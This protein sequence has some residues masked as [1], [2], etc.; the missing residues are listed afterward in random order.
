LVTAI[1]SASIK[2]TKT[3]FIV[4]VLGH[5]EFLDVE[6]FPVVVTPRFIQITQARK[7]K[8]LKIRSKILLHAGIRKSTTY[9]SE[10]QTN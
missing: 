10:D 2:E 9:Y 7:I 3:P 5:K 8:I 6:S 1:K 4:F